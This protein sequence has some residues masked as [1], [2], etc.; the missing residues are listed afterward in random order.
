MPFLLV[1]ILNFQGLTHFIGVDVLVSKICLF[2]ILNSS[3][4]VIM[5]PT[6]KKISVF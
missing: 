4:T 3:I 2:L 5:N 1:E 6:F